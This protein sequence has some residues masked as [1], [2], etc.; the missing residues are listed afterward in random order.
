M[1][2]A[3]EMDSSGG[4]VSA[5]MQPLLRPSWLPERVWPFGSLR[6]EV[7]GAG[8]AATDVG[9]GPALLFVHTGMWSFIWRDVM[10][11]LLNDFRCVAFDAPGTGQNDRLPASEISLE[12]ASR[13]VTAIIEA[14][15]LHDLTLVVHDL[16][17]PAGIA[18]AS[19]TPRRVR[20]L[21]GV[22]TFAWKP[23]GAI[24]RGMLAL[25]GSAPMREFDALSGL[26]ARVSAS[27][28]GA[29]RHL[30]GP[31]RDAF[32]AGIG[33]QGLR[34]FH[35]YMRDARQSNSIYERAGSALAGPF[36]TLPLL[37]IF[38]E[39]NDPFGFQQRWKRMFP[40]ARQLVV[41]KGNHFPMCDDPDLV[42]STI[43]SW[44]R[45]RV[46]PATR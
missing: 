2:S 13:A 34:T 25:M 7:D 16:G 23:S 40:D 30:D 41:A 14:L 9:E 12:R 45:E 10:T 17:G 46:V 11:R 27:S 26:L 43:R 32:R 31:S 33:R 38:G 8:V 15:D 4:G 5:A 3:L 37:T 22:N 39:R 1:K 36:K 24:F 42:A 21:V 20:G 29:G 35:R 19:R 44:H 28:F 18:G 6:L